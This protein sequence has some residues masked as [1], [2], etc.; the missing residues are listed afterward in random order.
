MFIL[1]WL[2]CENCLWFE[3]I[4]YCHHKDKLVSDD[5]RCPSWTC[6]YCG[7]AWNEPPSEQVAEGA[8]LINHFKCIPKK[9]K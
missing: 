4:S 5:G 3:L 7:L 6:M 1:H 9:K 8:K 2:Q